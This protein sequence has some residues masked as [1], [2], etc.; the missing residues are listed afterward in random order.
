[1]NS[2]SFCV[3]IHFK[4][5]PFFLLNAPSDHGVKIGCFFG[6]LFKGIIPFLADYFI[7]DR[8]QAGFFVHVVSNFLPF[9]PTPPPHKKPPQ[10]AFVLRGGG[11]SSFFFG[12]DLQVMINS[13]RIR[14]GSIWSS[15]HV[16]PPPRS[17]DR[18][19]A[20]RSCD[21]F[22]RSHFLHN[23]FPLIVV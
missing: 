4:R 12:G 1:M 21:F 8:Q 20:L 10:F 16:P 19:L 17:C 18:P 6:N 5:G 9:N 15:P 14:G 23:P 11:L 2:F 22:C 7:P 13:D 3:E